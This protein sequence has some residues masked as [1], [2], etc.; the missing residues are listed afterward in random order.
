MCTSLEEDQKRPT[1]RF[2]LLA[3]ITSAVETTSVIR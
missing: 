1:L 3:N 2:E